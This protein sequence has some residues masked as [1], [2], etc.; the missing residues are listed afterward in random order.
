MSNNSELKDVA[1]VALR[2][3]LEVGIPVT[4]KALNSDIGQTLVLL[5]VD[6]AK[7][8]LS[9]AH[10]KTKEEKTP[11]RAWNEADIAAQAEE[12]RKMTEKL[13]TPKR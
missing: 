2:L 9:S 4:K 8:I 10:E 7:D 11:K 5:A 12:V 6:V 13:N 1:K 3:G